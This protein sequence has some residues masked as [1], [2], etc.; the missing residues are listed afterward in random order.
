MIEFNEDTALIFFVANTRKISLGTDCNVNV[1]STVFDIDV[2]GVGSHT[3]VC[4][5]VF[6]RLE[7]S[8]NAPNSYGTET[9]EK[10]YE[11]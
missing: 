4:R 3:C 5:K 6:I 10:K 7:V 2:T 1:F 8:L 11:F 9:D